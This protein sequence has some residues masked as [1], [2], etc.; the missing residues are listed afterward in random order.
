MAAPDSLTAPKPLSFEGNVSQNWKKFIKSFTIYRKAA[1]KG[2]DAEQIAATFLNLAGEEAIEREENFS[3]KPAIKNDGGDITTPAETNDDPDVLIK[4][5]A[6]LCSPMTNVIM[7]RHTFNTR[8]QLPA[9]SIEQYVMD[10][11][12]IASSCEYS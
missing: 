9:E 12:K 11:K 6:E 1:L 7:E 10:L 8:S 2:K 5:F 4:K 3:Y